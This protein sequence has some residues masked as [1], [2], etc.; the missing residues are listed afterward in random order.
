MNEPFSPETARKIGLRAM[1]RAKAT[2]SAPASPPRG[3]GTPVVNVPVTV[4]AAPVPTFDWE[5]THIYDGAR[6]VRTISRRVP[7]AST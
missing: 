5:H 1:A 6:L 4:Q 3:D 2:A 7:R